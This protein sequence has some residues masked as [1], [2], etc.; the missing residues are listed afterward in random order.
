MQRIQVFL[1]VLILFLFAC[2]TAK[3]INSTAVPLAANLQTELLSAPDLAGAHI[4]FSVYD[5][6]TKDF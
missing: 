6:V 1:L 3:K 5:P 2:S 4:G